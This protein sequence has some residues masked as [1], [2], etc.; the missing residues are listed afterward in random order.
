M[1]TTLKTA[2]AYGVLRELGWRTAM[3]GPQALKDFQAGWALGDPLKVDGLLGPKTS[4]AL[5]QSRDRSHAGRADAS[6]HFSFAE[7]RCRCGG[8]AGCRA[9][10]P[11]YQL[12]DSLE[13][14]R[15]AFYKSG[16]TIASGCRCVRHNKIVGGA[17][18]SQHLYGTA[19]DVAFATSW[20]AVAGLQLFAGI[21]Y[22]RS[23]GLVRH[24]DRRD[25]S[26]VNPTRGSRR[27]PTSWVYAV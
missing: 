18:Q 20:R 11:R 1:M 15:G 8:Y 6:E 22:S 24:V 21:G 4:A 12:L 17:S 3:I 19:A 2:E 14:L 10:W 13:G 23:S 5:I 26:G 9:I 16:L 7:F 25:I 27:A